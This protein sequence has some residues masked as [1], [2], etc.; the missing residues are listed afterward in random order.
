MVDLKT[1]L[2]D[3]HV[4][5]G[6]KM[7]PFA[8][9]LLP[10]TYKGTS[11]MIEHQAVRE[12]AG[13][14]DVSHMG[15][16]VITGKDALSNLQRLLTNDF[17]TM[18]NGQVRYTLMLNQQGG[19][20]DD[21][22]VYK[23]ND[24]KFLLVVNAANRLTDGQW[25]ASH[26]TGDCQMSDESDE[27][28]I[29]ALQG[30]KA[31]EILKQ[32]MAEEDI[33]SK[34]Y[35]FNENVTLG[36]Q[37]VMISQTGYTGELGYELYVNSVDAVNLWQQLLQAGETAGL[38]PC[39]L[40]ARDTLRLEAGMPLYG[41]EMTTEISPLETG[42]SF[43]VKMAKDDFIGKEALIDQGEPQIKRVG[44]KVTGKGIVR[45]EAKIYAD[46]KEVG[47]STSGTHSPTLGY[48]IAMALIEKEFAELGTALE[49]EVRGRR[50]PVEVVSS[51]FYKKTK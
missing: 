26:L 12:Q 35:R 50:I 28:A 44:L 10:V 32:L 43:A 23:Y 49:A 13:L 37:Q 24:Q 36:E 15:S 45:E 22:I 21:F 33:P 25:I 6:G 7:V 11:L 47:T 51:N 4:A 5:S 17:T 2:Y 16:L 19:V 42:L 18:A 1:P 9:Y 30:P 34:Y 46:G 40:G 27:T 38:I 39:G 3:T 8:G 20:I 29:L 14:F 48:P 31:T 41:H